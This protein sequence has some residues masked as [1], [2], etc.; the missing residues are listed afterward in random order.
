MPKPHLSMV[1]IQE[2]AD[3]AAEETLNLEYD[4]PTTIED[5]TLPYGYVTQDQGDIQVHRSLEAA[6]IAQ[7]NSFVGMYHAGAE[8]ACKARAWA[9]EAFFHPSIMSLLY[10]PTEHHFAIYTPY[11]VP[12][13]LHTFLAAMKE[14]TRYRR[15]RK[16]FLISNVQQHA[17]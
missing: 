11:F 9:E 2:I 7:N 14:V 10:F 1:A 13:L 5:D 16:K 6:K 8:S 4:S 3:E 17:S 12:V 15:E